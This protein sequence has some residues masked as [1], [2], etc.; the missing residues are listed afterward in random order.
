MKLTIKK[1]R[2]RSTCADL[3]ILQNGVAKEKVSNLQLYVLHICFY[4]VTSTELG[5]KVL[6]NALFSD[7]IFPQFKMF[8]ICD[9]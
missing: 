6:K 9:F 4:Q 7:Y 2:D 8:T 3:Q 5:V 1:H